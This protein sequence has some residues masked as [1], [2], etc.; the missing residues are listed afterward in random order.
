MPKVYPSFD[1]PEVVIHKRGNGVTFKHKRGAHVFKLERDTPFLA[2]RYPGRDTKAM[3]YAFDFFNRLSVVAEDIVDRTCM[4]ARCNQADHGWYW[5]PKWYRAKE[6]TKM[7]RWLR[8]ACTGITSLF[9]EHMDAE[10]LADSLLLYSVKAQPPS[11]W[12]MTEYVPNMEHRDF[13]WN[14]AARATIMEYDQWQNSTPW[15][16]GYLRFVEGRHVP[17]TSGQRRFIYGMPGRCYSS[18]AA[19]ILMEW[20]HINFKIPPERMVWRLVAKL[21]EKHRQGIVTDDDVEIRLAAIQRSSM[22]NIRKGLHNIMLGHGYTSLRTD[23]ALNNVVNELCDGG[24]RPGDDVEQWSRRAR[25]EHEYHA[26]PFDNT[27]FRQ[28]Q[29]DMELERPDDP[30]PLITRE[31]PDG[32]TQLASRH[33][34]ANETVLMDHCVATYASGAV[35]G[36]FFLLHYDAEDGMSTVKL[37]L[38]GRVGQSHDV[39]NTFTPASERAAEIIKEW[40]SE[41]PFREEEVCKSTYSWERL[42]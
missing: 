4:D 23:A 7:T 21:M 41:G 26:L 10:M 5:V 42:W 25:M 2:H 14:Y 30:C 38:D 31:L 27:P 33:A 32:F 37:E 1:Y 28:R 40:A 20:E 16:D 18:D 8:K 22:Y 29:A 12:L 35:D 34:I 24:C 6:T 3:V 19:D 9:R 15:I 39:G 13:R 36:N 11:Y 17:L